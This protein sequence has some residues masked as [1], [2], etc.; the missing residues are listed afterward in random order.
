MPCNY[1]TTFLD[2]YLR[3]IVS[4][5]DKLF[6]QLELFNLTQKQLLQA[7]CD[8]ASDAVL[9]AHL[10]STLLKITDGANE[11]EGDF[12]ELT[13]E[14]LVSGKARPGPESPGMLARGR[15]YEK[16]L[17]EARLNTRVQKFLVM[18]LEKDGYL[19]DYLSL[20]LP[21]ARC[22]KIGYWAAACNFVY[23]VMALIKWR[24]L[25]NW[26]D[27][28]NGRRGGV[29]N[30]LHRVLTI[31][32]EFGY[33]ELVERLMGLEEVDHIE[34]TRVPICY[35]FDD[36]H[37]RDV[38]EHIQRRFRKSGC[39]YYYAFKSRL[40]PLNLAAKLGDVVMVNTLLACK[41]GRVWRSV[42]LHWAA[43]MGHNEVVNA[44]LL[45]KEIEFDV[46]QAVSMVVD[47]SLTVNRSS[48]GTHGFFLPGLDV[49]KRYERL[50]NVE[51]TPLQLASLY[52]HISVVKVLCHN[53]KGCLGATF[54][55]DA[56]VTALQIA[57]DMKNDEIA[58]ILTDIPEVEKQVE[59]LYRDRQVHVDAA[60]AILVVAALIASVTF[61]GW[62]QPP[63]GYSPFFGSAS[64]GAGSPTPSGMYPSFVSVEGH[65]I[66]KIFWVFNSMSFF[67][68][69][70]TLMVG[71][72]AA[73]PPKKDTYIGVVVQSLRTLLRLAYALLTISVA[74]VM[75]A[76]A[77]AGFVMLP[78]I[79]IY[80]SI[81]Q[82]TVGIGVM[83]VFL[84]WT[85]STLLKILFKVISRI[86]DVVAEYV[87]KNSE[88]VAA[89]YI[90]ENSDPIVRIL[91]T[92]RS[93][94]ELIKEKLQINN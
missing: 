32:V 86:E 52:G 82:A 22:L 68:A 69:I 40:T 77:S 84:A 66:M 29:R 45:N 3:A 73:R 80:T 70:A 56:G 28:P 43:K 12:A 57:T 61:A 23:M 20:N 93:I 44:I 83:V 92:L 94:L 78:P 24:D 60:N 42:P 46:N 30:F 10:D 71:A 39:L 64:P 21:E 53:P 8:D 58:K 47:K 31:A 51:C 90:T 89:W 9:R 36:V 55:N 4:N 54:E 16:A 1:D 38:G 7:I 19:T 18:E 13:W 35:D 37:L 26:R 5:Y 25:T 2:A 79:R 85:S 91:P 65:P 11:E 48:Y 62:L 15:V 75:G 27:L 50:Y 87:Y 67:F 14:E 6:R 81:M 34:S 76:F 74:C 17:G 59:R 63:L 41:R 49:S 33:V 88:E 72:T